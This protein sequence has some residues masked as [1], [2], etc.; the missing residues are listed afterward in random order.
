MQ[1][2]IFEFAGTTFE[3]PS[4]DSPTFG[5][6]KLNA[7]KTGISTENRML[8]F[9]IRIDNSGSMSD[10]C[11][12]GRTKMQHVNFA[13]SQI[14]RKLGEGSIQTTA[15]IKTFDDSIVQIIDGPL[16]SDTA[17][18]MV[19]LVN[20][21]FPNG[22]TNIYNVLR[23]EENTQH[24]SEDRIFV[25][26]SDGQDT[27]GSGRDKVIRTA[28]QIDANTN[29]IM[30]GVG[31]DHD[32]NLFKGI[33]NRRSCG[34]YTPVSNVEDIAIAISELVYGFLNKILKR[35]KITV[36]DGEIYSWSANKWVSSI[37][38][39]DIVMGR[40]K[41]FIVRSLTP[42][43]FRAKVE[44]VCVE[45][46]ASFA[47]ELI[48]S[49]I[50]ADLTYDKH[51]HGT[52]ELLG[53]SVLADQMRSAEM[54]DLKLRLKNKMI[55]LKAYMD[56][57]KLRHD[58]RYQVLCDDIFMCHQTMGSEHGIM[59]AAARQTSQG[60]QSIYT[61]QRDLTPRISRMSTQ[62][63]MS[64][65]LT[66]CMDEMELD[67]LPDIPTIRRG[68]TSNIHQMTQENLM[69]PIKNNNFRLVE[70]DEELDEEPDDA[71]LNHQMLASHDSPYAN[72]A[73]MAFIREVS[74]ASK[75]I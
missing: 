40:N 65:A 14:L 22:G 25:M 56:E 59:Y 20:K 55:E 74:I 6:I 9:Q 38:T 32:S 72:A 61:N 71:M 73:E 35:S 64:R 75:S 10:I 15:N 43:L 26:L 27:S 69:S 57:H 58:K 39:A 41:T 50:G 12:D 21:I 54:R 48:D 28:A 37:T 49:E 68:V 31:N 70:I 7:T 5:I 36:S 33:V 34:H 30:I 51:R 2:Q 3:T 46:G 67:D 60:T 23:V 45:N 11:N 42:A 1:Q 44:G 4:L 24:S 16:N 29:V 17:E 47:M 63:V 62:P 53:E 8:D 19:T 18:G 13:V 52:M 66:Q